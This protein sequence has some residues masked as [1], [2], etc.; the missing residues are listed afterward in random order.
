MNQPQKKKPTTPQKYGHAR[1]IIPIRKRIW[2][3]VL[4]RWALL[5]ALA[6]V[7]VL[8]CIISE[9]V[10]T[11]RN[12]PQMRQL[13]RWLTIAVWLFIFWQSHV[14]KLTFSKEWTGTV[15]GKEV[16]KYNKIPQG[17][18]SFGVDARKQAGMLATKCVWSVEKDNGSIEEV[19][20]DTE[21][22][23]EGYFKVGER[24]RFYK[25]AKILVKAHPPKD[26][27]N[28]MCPLCGVMVMEP[29]C[30]KCGVDFAEP[31]EVAAERES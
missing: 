31:E 11:L 19:H 23:W 5:L 1:R 10:P 9:D 17:L 24:V 25:N 28:L 22:I 15:T 14:L 29:I 21:E 20:C 27:E 13:G 26:D 7:F 3:K 4:I 30:K 12:Y 18:A 2:Q 16:Q 8:L 6:G